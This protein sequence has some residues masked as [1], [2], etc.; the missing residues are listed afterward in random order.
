MD[1]GGW[2]WRLALVLAIAFTARAGAAIAIDAR[3]PRNPPGQDLIPGD[4]AGYW[5]L[6]DNLAE[7]R[8]YADYTPP[9]RVMRMPGFPAVLA[10]S[11]VTFGKSPLAARLLLSA[12]AALGCWL[13][14]LLGR[15]LFD[16]R[17]ALLAAAITAVLP[18]F[19]AFSP[20][21]LSETVFAVTLVAS[22]IPAASLLKG[23]GDQKASSGK[24]LCQAGICGA[25]I[26]LACYMRPSWLLWAPFVALCAI[27]AGRARPIT[28]GVA[29][30][31]GATT[32]L[33]LLP[34]A[35]RNQRVTGH[36]VLTTLWMGPSLYDGLNPNATGDSEMSFFDRENL[37][38][39]MSEYEMNE[40]YAR[41]AKEFAKNN[42]LRALE[43][44][45]IKLARYWKPWPNAG[46]FNNWTAWIA[47]LASS[48]PLFAGTLLGIWKGRPG[49]IPLVLCLGPVLYFA[50][51]HS[52]FVG[53][54]RYRLPAEY[55]MS[56]LAAAGLFA[57]F[58]KRPN[59][60]S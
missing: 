3:V 48:I 9:R 38:A 16:V 33:T 10:L 6:A 18:T 7:G 39:T 56:L 11:F 28:W 45:F 12:V 54:I 32:F 41:R 4:A 49:W 26:S 21:F 13:V 44:G 53:S 47:V 27:V 34:W 24:L 19:V 22:L 31:L 40:E 5:H 25:L 29:A 51:I 14:Y 36:F 46:Q 43:L 23:L 42:P 20:L 8:E 37:L 52:V 58:G 2:S 50:A 60:E 57:T 15:R 55:P 17:T 35:V 1:R 59:P 30:V